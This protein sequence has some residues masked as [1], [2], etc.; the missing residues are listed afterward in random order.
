MNEKRVFSNQQVLDRLK[1]LDIQL[2]QVDMTNKNDQ[3]KTKDLARA[4]RR[5][6]PVNLVYPA[7]YPNSPAIL[8]EELISPKDALRALDR[9]TG[10][11]KP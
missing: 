4:D 8:L 2:V 9:L 11:V 3:T 5:I 1:E 6:I 7:D 10:T